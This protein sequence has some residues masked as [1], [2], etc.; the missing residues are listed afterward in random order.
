MATDE[1]S[2]YF[3]CASIPCWKETIRNGRALEFRRL[4]GYSCSGVVLGRE[5]EEMAIVRYCNSEAERHTCKS[6]LYDGDIPSL[7]LSAANKSNEFDKHPSARHT[8]SHPYPSLNLEEV[9][10]HLVSRTH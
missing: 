8:S 4:F 6:C 3:F 5:G 2:V 10:L 7:C 9:P 1:V